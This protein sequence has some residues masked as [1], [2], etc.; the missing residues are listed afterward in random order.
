MRGVEEVGEDRLGGLGG[1][2][3]EEGGH[4]LGGWVD[5]KGVGLEFGV[6]VGLAGL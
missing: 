3:D 5:S 4:G 1:G 6:R 2:G